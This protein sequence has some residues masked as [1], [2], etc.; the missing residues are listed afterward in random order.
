MEVPHIFTTGDDNKTAKMHS[1]NLTRN[2]SE[3]YICP[4]G[5][6]FSLSSL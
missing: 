2:V 4:Y 5:A 1:Q 3:T 6:K